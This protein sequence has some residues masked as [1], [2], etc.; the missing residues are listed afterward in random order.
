MILSDCK[1]HHGFNKKFSREGWEE[2]YASIAIEILPDFHTKM[3]NDVH[4][5]TEEMC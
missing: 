4:R 3:E 2:K 5:R 1:M